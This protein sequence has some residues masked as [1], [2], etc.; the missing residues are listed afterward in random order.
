MNTITKMYYGRDVSKYPA[1]FGQ[2]WKDEEVAQLLE[3]IQQEKSIEE[4][5]TAHERTPGGIKAELKILAVTYF[6]QRRPMKE[7]TKLI[8]LT[9][10][11]VE[12]AVLKSSKPKPEKKTTPS[13]MKEVVALVK[14]IQAKLATLMSKLPTSP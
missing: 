2:P 3:L 5:A 10:E 6:N 8:G 4:I 12:D 9:A 13:D 7:I 14:E 11:Q 1:R